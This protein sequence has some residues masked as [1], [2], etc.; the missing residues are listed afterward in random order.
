PNH[1][2]LAPRSHSGD[3]LGAGARVAHAPDAEALARVL[4][5]RRSGP[6]VL[7]LRLVLR[8]VDGRRAG[9]GAARGAAGAARPACPGADVGA[10]PGRQ[11]GPTPS[12]ARCDA[13]A[14]LRRAAGPGWTWR[15]ARRSR[16]TAG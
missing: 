16:R 6:G 15:P 1:P 12:L 10:A 9:A 8:R 4:S 11:P 7:S 5:R 13:G 14:A 2:R 3:A